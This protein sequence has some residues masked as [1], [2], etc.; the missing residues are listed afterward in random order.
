MKKYLYQL[1]GITICIILFTACKKDFLNVVPKGNQVAKTFNDYELI[2]NSPSLYEYNNQRGGPQVEALMGDDV[3]AESIYFSNAS[4]ATQKAFRW[5]DDIYSSSEIAD[6]LR[7]NL[8]SLYL[9]N[10]VIA[11]VIDSEGGTGQQKKS[12]MAEALANRAFLYF[13]FIN[14]YAKPYLASTA[15]SDPGFPII[16]TADITQ[17]DFE[18]NT[19]QQVYDFMISDLKS[20]IVDLPVQNKFAT[21][22]SKG[23]AEGLLGKIYLFMGRNADALDLFEAALTH[24]T[25]QASPAKLYNYNAEFADGGK[26]MPIQLSGPSNSPGFNVIDYREAL[27]SRIFYNGP[28]RGNND[29]NT[30]FI[31]L[32]PKAAALFDPSDLRLNFYGPYFPFQEPN[33]SGR[34]SKYAAQYARYGIELPDLLLMKAEAQAKLGNL[35]SA[36]ADVEILRRNRMPEAN[37]FVPAAATADQKALISFIMDERVRE[38]A[39][40]GYHWLDMRRM[41]VDP[42]F[43]GV[44]Y[45]HVLYKDE[46]STNTNVYTLR[47]Q[48]LTRKLPPLFMTANPSFVNNP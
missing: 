6:D 14:G 11:E 42:M 38:F 29:F 15:S 48:R 1:L 8:A 25:A 24:N 20:A 13:Q 4:S 34:L 37:S 21:R 7:G 39:T 27:V 16:R 41:S 47:L 5:E 36:V 18:R 3:A 35:N 17:K 26:F 46:T 28:G 30:D 2:M 45:T 44:T 43:S 19:V 12:L 10:K 40:Q 31:V 23:A 9:V 22:F 33:P 32:S